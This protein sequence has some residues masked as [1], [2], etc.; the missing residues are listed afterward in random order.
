MVCV[1][2]VDSSILILYNNSASFE[3]RSGEISLNLESVCITNFSDNGSLSY[4]YCCV[5]R[6]KRKQ[7]TVVSNTSSTINET[8]M[9]EG[10]YCAQN[11]IEDRQKGTLKS[12]S[13][14]SLA[15]ISKSSTIIDLINHHASR[16]ASQ[17]ERGNQVV[18]KQLGYNHILNLR[19]FIDNGI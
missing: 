9:C 13:R 16:T 2:K 15:P 7:I 4:L 19:R 6:E 8:N 14:I 5:Y 11:H 3:F 12:A 10:C 1:D 18:M 17:G